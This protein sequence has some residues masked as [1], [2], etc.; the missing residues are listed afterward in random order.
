MNN[1]KQTSKPAPDEA[2]KWLKKQA[3]REA[4]A[5]QTVDEARRKLDRAEQKLDRARRSVEKRQA[6]LQASE[7]KLED[8][9]RSSAPGSPPSES[10]DEE[11]GVGGS[12]EGILIGSPE[13]NQLEQLVAEEL[14]EEEAAAAINH[15]IEALIGE[16]S[17]LETLSI[18][19]PSEAPEAA[20]SFSHEQTSAEAGSL[21]A[22]GS[23]PVEEQ[24]EEIFVF[25]ETIV[26]AP[27]EL[28]SVQSNGTEST[29]G[30]APPSKESSASKAPAVR[31]TRS[32]AAGAAGAAGTSPRRRVSS[33]RAQTTKAAT[34]KTPPSDPGETN[35]SE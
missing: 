26:A 5:L 21:P 8:V 17:A 24:P 6:N 25:Q 30:E 11:Q 7:A 19:E 4:S 20:A 15:A 31:R 13:V 16:E 9:R 3:R 10:L 27:E 23:K 33:S 34:N 2:R 22:E 1:Q 18:F 35:G 28:S 32:G 14:I 29:Q 12:G